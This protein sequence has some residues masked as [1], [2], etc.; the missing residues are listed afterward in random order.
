[1]PY[2]NLSQEEII[3]SVAH[4]PC[5]LGQ[6]LYNQFTLS[7]NQKKHPSLDDIFNIE[8]DYIDL[9][10]YKRKGHLNNYI[11]MYHPEIYDAIIQQDGYY[12]FKM[13]CDLLTLKIDDI[14][15]CFKNVVEA[16]EIGP[17]TKLPVMSKTVPLLKKLNQWFC[18]DVY[19]AMDICGI[20]AQQ[21]CQLVQ[22]QLP[23]IKTE[24]IEIDFLSNKILGNISNNSRNRKKIIFS[25]GQSIFANNTP[26]GTQNF[27]NNV[28]LL[29][30]QGDY[31]LFGIDTNR[32]EETLEKAYKT[33]ISHE[34][35]LNTMYYL[36][37]ALNLNDFN[38]EAFGLIYQWDRSKRSVNIFLRPTCQQELRIRN[39]F[40]VINENHEF[41]ITSSKK[42][43]I[44]TINQYL[45]KSFLEIKN[46]ISLGCEVG[47]KLSLIIAQKSERNI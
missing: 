19:K 3:S 6:N 9:F 30:G 26:Q 42:P 40:F 2:I 43:D 34:L 28:A 10:S 4:N 35:V 18:L 39:E 45:S 7:N 25:L 41:H 27:L 46:I 36:K 44:G 17:G 37:E 5:I 24:A 33:P 29:L 31:L 8:Q 13:E 22:E 23:N 21:A 11:Y 12:P 38:P 32:N 1:M 15:A 16:I 47:N 20:Y 14:I